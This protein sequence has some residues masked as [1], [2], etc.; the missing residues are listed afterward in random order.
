MTPEQKRKALILR[1]KQAQLQ[2]PEQTGWD[3]FRA[4]WLPD[5]DPTSHNMGE[6]VAAGINKAGEALTFGLIGDEADARVKS[7]LGP[8]TYDEE[9]AKNRQQEEVFEQ[10]N[11]CCVGCVADRRR[12]SGRSSAPWH[13]RNAGPGRKGRASCGR[14]WCRRRRNGWHLWVYGR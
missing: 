9:L 1:Q 2:V 4:N 6:K 14:V 8:G 3:R 12:A 7:W 5:D 10:E 11:P 13:H